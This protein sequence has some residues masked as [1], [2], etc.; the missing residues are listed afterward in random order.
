MARF[1]TEDELLK[2]A[3]K[4]TVSRGHIKPSMISAAE[5]IWL[6]SIDSDFIDLLVDDPSTYRE[7]VEEYIKPIVAFGTVAS[8]FDYITTAIT[9]KG[10]VQM[11]NLE[12]AAS[13]IGRDSRLDTEIE[14]RNLAGRLVKIA[15]EEGER[16]R[17][18]EE[19]PAFED[20]EA[21]TAPPRVWNVWGD[22]SLNLRPY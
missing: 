8:Y 22:R 17:D 16:K 4:G 6:S 7:Y 21:I 20:F 5:N 15:I 11:M 12:G 3:V 9:D 2:I 14:L 10:V 18:I 19:D 1:L 13:V